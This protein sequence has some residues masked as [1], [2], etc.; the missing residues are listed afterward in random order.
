MTLL[1]PHPSKPRFRDLQFE[2]MTDVNPP[3][4]SRFRFLLGRTKTNETRK[5][6]LITSPDHRLSV[7]QIKKHTST[8][9]IGP[10]SGISRHRP[11]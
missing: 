1:V 2:L 6:R 10:R 9:W 3:L 5:F 11:F 7:E 8:T 4:S